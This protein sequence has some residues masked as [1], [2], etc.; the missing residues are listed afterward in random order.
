MTASE[1][2]AHDKKKSVT[3]SRRDWL[4]II[5]RLITVYEEVAHEVF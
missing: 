4:G 1:I 3:D 2:Q 5:F